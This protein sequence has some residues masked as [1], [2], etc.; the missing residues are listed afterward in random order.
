VGHKIL[1]V[2]DEADLV[3]TCVRVLSRRGYACLRAYMGRE[4]LALIDEKRPHI[5]LTDLSLPDIDGFTLLR[6]ARAKSPSIPG[7]LMTAYNSPGTIERAAEAGAH[8]C[9]AKPF[10]NSA[11]LEAIEGALH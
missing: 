6:H 1:I 8:V 9:L 5:V 7:I 11:L 10:S 3:E 4:G 2:D